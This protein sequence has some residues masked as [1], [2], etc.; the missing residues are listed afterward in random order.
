MHFDT[1]SG[2]GMIQGLECVFGGL[3]ASPFVRLYIQNPLRKSGKTETVRSTQSIKAKAVNKVVRFVFCQPT[4]RVGSNTT[5]NT[6]NAWWLSWVTFWC[7]NQSNKIPWCT[8]RR[9]QVFRL[10][11]KSWDVQWVVQAIPTVPDVQSVRANSHFGH[12]RNSVMRR[13]IMYH[14]FRSS[15][16]GLGLTCAE[17]SHVADHRAKWA[18]S[19]PMIP[20]RHRAEAKMI[21]GSL[22][23]GP[24]SPCL[25]GVQTVMV[26]R[27]RV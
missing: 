23:G 1:I 14:L 15:F 21:I 25:V 7:P 2:L 16:G 12:A 18:V 11:T 26:G 9:G 17:R 24:N 5:Q 8:C 4:R 13:T 10:E 27:W 22:Q 3:A 20:E 19:L 6:P